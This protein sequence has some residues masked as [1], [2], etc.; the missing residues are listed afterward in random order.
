MWVVTCHTVL[1]VRCMH[2]TPLQQPRAVY[3]DSTCM[4]CHMAAVADMYVLLLLLLLLWSQ[5]WCCW[6]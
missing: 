3:R 4:K 2:I 6:C 1:S 5:S